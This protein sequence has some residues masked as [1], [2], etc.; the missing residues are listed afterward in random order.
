M[1]SILISCICLSLMFSDGQDKKSLNQSVELFRKSMVS[2]DEQAL[3]KLTSPTLSYGHS[4]G[5][6]ENQKEFVASMK[7]A[8]YKFVSIELT[9]QTV[10]LS[11]KDVAVVRHHF[12]AHTADTGKPKSTINL[13]VLTVWKKLDAKWV[14]L[15]RQAVKI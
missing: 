2:V 13:H 8:K 3:L 11:Y 1:K 6:I 7:S 4:N 12:F 10:D 14:L 9:D 5:I 15:T